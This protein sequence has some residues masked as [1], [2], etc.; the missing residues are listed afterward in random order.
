M[1]DCQIYLLTPSAL[2]PAAFASELAAALDAGEIACVLLLPESLGDP[3]DDALRAAIDRLRPITQDRGVAFLVDGRPD[4][5][6]ET[7]CDGAHTCPDGP[8]YAEARRL[9]GPNAIVG[10]SARFSRD[11]A[12]T[13]A[14]QGADYIVF[15]RR[16][17][18][19]AEQAETLDLIEWW[20]SM[21]EVPCVALGDIGPETCAPF[22][23][24]G[25]DFLAVDQSIWAHPGG[26]A[27]GVAAMKEVIATHRA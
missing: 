25:A 3:T 12:M 15:G 16:S 26:P 20:A 6:A 2:E 8:S 4:L 21:M 11:A 9:V 14:D 22:V 1:P 27:A 7:G 10:Y 23:K 24:A 17:P 13:V 19:P 18:T 5:A